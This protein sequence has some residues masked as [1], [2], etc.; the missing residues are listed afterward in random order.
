MKNQCSD[1]LILGHLNINSLPNKFDAL[2]K[3]IKNNI[4]I[5]ILSETKLDDSFP[6]AQFKLHGFRDP[7]RLDRNSRGGGILVY[8]R[9]DIPSKSVNIKS[10]CSIESITID[11]NLRKRK[12]LLNCSYNPHKNLIKNHL[13]CLSRIIDELGKKYDNCIFVGD[14]NVCVKEKSMEAFCSLNEFS[15]LN[16]KPTC[17]KNFDNPTC[18]DLILTNRPSYF[19]HTNVLETG[20]SDFHLMVVTQFK[21][22]FSKLAP[23]IVIVIGITKSLTMKHFDQRFKIMFLTTP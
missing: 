23:K 20:L 1:K 4:D 15:S 3:I 19:Q 11:I 8:I 16:D 2:K 22:G 14:F 5:L 12:W 7:Y 13:E 17:Y 9:E 21:M 10:D 6:D 18:I